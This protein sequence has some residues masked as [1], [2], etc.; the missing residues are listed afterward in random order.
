MPVCPH[1]PT[2]RPNMD[3]RIYEPYGETRGAG[4]YGAALEYGHFLWHRQL[5]ARA[6][7][8]LDRAMGA[9]LG[10]DE[11]VVNSWPIPYAAMAWFLRE[12]P[13]ELFCGNPRVHFQHYADRMNAPRKEV[14]QWRAW[15]CWAIARTVRPELPGDPRHT[16][17]E[18]TWEAIGAGLD[19]A[20]LPGE[21]EQWAAVRAG[22][23]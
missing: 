9:D 13:R 15:A 7:L 5:P 4:F 10:G 21:A 20:G 23:F 3:W 16:V 14:R 2:P 19:A 8:C 12:V 11:P 18:P 17:V 22:R 6:I 1:L